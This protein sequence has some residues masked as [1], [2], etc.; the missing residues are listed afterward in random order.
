MTLKEVSPSRL[1]ML[2][3][4]RHKPTSL[5]LILRLNL[6]DRPT[7]RLRALLQHNPVPVLR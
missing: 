6:Y 7:R 2:H 3:S 4:S 1:L 5:R